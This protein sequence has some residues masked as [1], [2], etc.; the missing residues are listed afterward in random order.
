MIKGHEDKDSYYDD[1]D[2]D[3]IPVERNYNRL[4]REEERER[5]ESSSTDSPLTVR[6]TR[7]YGFA[8]M[9]SVRGY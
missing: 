9:P 2:D 7:E 5:G 1:D 4:T 3:V 6:K 8:K